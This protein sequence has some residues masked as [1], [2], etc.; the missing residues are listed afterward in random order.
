MIR[1][2]AFEPFLRLLREGTIRMYDY[3]FA[4]APVSIEGK[5]ALINIQD[6]LQARPNTFSR[7]FLRHAD[8][9]HAIGSATLHK[10]FVAAARTGA[11][12]I[13]ADAFGAS[14]ENAKRDHETPKRT[15]RIVQ[16]FVDELYAFR[17]LADRP[18]ITAEV[19]TVGVDSQ[20]RYNVDFGGLAA[21]AGPELN[22]GPSTPVA[23]SVIA[24][25]LIWSGLSQKCDL[26]LSSPMS[27]LV[28]DKLFEAQRYTT[29]K[30]EVIQQLQQEVEFPDVRTLVN[31][32]ELRFA[33]VLA[34]RRKSSRFRGWLQDESDRDR[35]A[36]IAYHQEVARE[37]KLVGLGRKTLRVLG[38]LGGGAIG[39]ALGAVMPGVEMG[40]FAGAAGAG[41]SYL[42][43]VG[44]SLGNEWR[45]VV[46]GN[47]MK[48]R[49][50]R[51]LR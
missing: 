12:E 32:G 36:I 19:R 3:A 47:W 4:S 45:P 34:I 22:F 39:G 42:I 48:D 20:I 11:I 37:T 9:R 27:I 35:N 46:F 50:E 2:G 6:V 10:Q 21:V 16:A 28:G 14:I 8:V 51:V 7:R 15:A 13:K 31:S 30:H 29:R 24:N 44:T 18:E 25:R 38:V 17:R 1:Q 43:D 41:V 26:F 5:F 40:A 23:G 33:D 49:I